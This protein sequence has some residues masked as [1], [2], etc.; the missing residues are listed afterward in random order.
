MDQPARE[1]V[2]HGIYKHY[3]GGLYIVEDI[4]IHSETDEQ[5]VIYRAL[6]GDAP[7]FARPLE[8]FLGKHDGKN[9]RFTLQ[10]T[11]RAKV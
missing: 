9:D 1:I 5:L 2:I 4:A 8:M 10:P 7:L 3:K 6:Y 11:K